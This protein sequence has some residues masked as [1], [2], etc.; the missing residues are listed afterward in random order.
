MLVPLLSRASSPHRGETAKEPTPRAH[1]PG[2]RFLTATQAHGV[3][4]HMDPSHGGASRP[5]GGSMAPPSCSHV[6]SRPAAPALCLVSS[7]G[8][9]TICPHSAQAAPWAAL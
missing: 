5:A 2:V 8:T 1:F 7:W 9:T 6:V 4:A 3:P